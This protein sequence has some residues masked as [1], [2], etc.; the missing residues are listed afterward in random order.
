MAE[1]SL[2]EEEQSLWRQIRETVNGFIPRS[3]RE[4]GAHNDC[5]LNPEGEGEANGGDGGKK[6][7]RTPTAAE[8]NLDKLGKQLKASIVD[9]WK[10]WA[11]V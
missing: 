1:A 6:A 5:D 7:K 3:K 9:E 11:L 8:D 10:Y 4:P 2:S